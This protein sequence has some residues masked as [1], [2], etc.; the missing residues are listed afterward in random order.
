MSN[1]LEATRQNV[2]VTGNRILDALVSMYS[3][4]ITITGVMDG[5]TVK[6]QGAID[7]SR[8]VPRMAFGIRSVERRLYREDS[9]AGFGSCARSEERRV[10]K[11]CRSRW[12]PYH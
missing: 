2:E 4:G 8:P 11:E 12:S 3:P 6:S 7:L 10:G 1:T 9:H 5:V